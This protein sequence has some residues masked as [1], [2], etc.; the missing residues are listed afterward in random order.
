MHDVISTIETERG[1]GLSPRFW[2]KLGGYRIS[3]R[4]WCG[5]PLS[6]KTRHIH[7]HACDVFNL[8]LGVHQKGVGF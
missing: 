1:G 6:T 3:E 4:A 7:I 5:L 2:A 8:F